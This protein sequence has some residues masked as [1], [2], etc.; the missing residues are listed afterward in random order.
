MNG[1]VSHVDVEQGL[2]TVFLA[3]RF[4]SYVVTRR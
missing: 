2:R 4:E 3:S 1:W